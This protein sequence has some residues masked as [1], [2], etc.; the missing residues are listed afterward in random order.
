MAPVCEAIEPVVRNTL[1]FVSKDA[2]VVFDPPLKGPNVRALRHPRLLQQPLD[3]SVRV[4]GLL[5][6]R[7]RESVT[8]P[9]VTSST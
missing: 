7:A 8:I 6:S 2:E 9:A 1:N 5:L 3:K 4:S